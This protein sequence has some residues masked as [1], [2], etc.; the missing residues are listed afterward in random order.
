MLNYVTKT[1]LFFISI[2]C[3]L[4]PLTF[5]S[6][7]HGLLLRLSVLTL[8]RQL[9]LGPLFVWSYGDLTGLRNVFTLKTFHCS[10]SMGPASIIQQP[11]H[12]YGIADIHTTHSRAAAQNTFIL[13]CMCFYTYA[14]DRSNRKR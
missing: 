12:F 8:L 7:L 9:L 10:A 14:V 1:I 6:M 4:C 3:C 13:L 11:W 5:G 2:K